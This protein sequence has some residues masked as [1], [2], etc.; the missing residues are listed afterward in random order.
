[1][2][3]SSD[4]KIELCQEPLN[5]PCCTQAEAYGVLLFCN[6]FSPFGIRITTQS[7][8]F[9]NRL[10]VLFQE[11][12]GVAFDDQPEELD[13]P[14]KLTFRITNR[15]SIRKILDTYGYSRE[16]LMS[17]HIN[18][19]VLEERCCQVA[20]CRGAFLAGGSVTDPIKGY[21]L[22]ITTSHMHVHREI[23][24]LMPELSLFPRE[25]TRKSN[26]ITYFKQNEAIARFLTTIG[27]P[28]SSKGII[29]ARKQKNLRN[30]VNRQYNCDV[31]NVEK[32]VQAAQTQI[33]AIRLLELRGELELLPEKLKE[34]AEL[35]RTH[36]ELSL[37]QL[38]ALC[39]PPVSKSC[40]NHRLR[41]LQELASD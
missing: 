30:G 39:H 24:A 35:R 18:Y 9:A 27:A 21:H 32:A 2:S 29:D 34:T 10:P 4:V 28:E 19:A 17:H 6:N 13:V 3:F 1:M 26:Y 38:A 37:V 11:A 12:F 36:P 5:S 31:A 7:H 40:L 23:Q 16:Q 8:A 22:E 25:T 15:D 33:E 41:K 14:G 20:F